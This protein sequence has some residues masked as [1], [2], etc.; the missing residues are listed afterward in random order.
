[1]TAPEPS[2]HGDARNPSSGTSGR[3]EPVERLSGR[4]SAQSREL[5]PESDEHHANVWF[6][7]TCRLI[8]QR[9]QPITKA[10]KGVLDDADLTFNWEGRS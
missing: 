1:M 2:V 7:L 4:F 9:L 6:C 8:E 3:G 5:C 10:L